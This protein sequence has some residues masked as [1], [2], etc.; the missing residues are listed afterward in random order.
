V[1]QQSISRWLIAGIDIANTNNPLSIVGNN[2]KHGLTNNH[3]QPITL[4]PCRYAEIKLRAERRAGEMLREQ[5]SPGNPQF[6]HDERIVPLKDLGISESQ[7]HRWQTEASL[8]EEDFEK[9]L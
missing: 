8:P 6:L 7:S 9:P 1:P 3:H 2:A 4:F 5:V